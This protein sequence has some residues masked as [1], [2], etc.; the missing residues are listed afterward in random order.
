MD[1]FDGRVAVVTGGGSGIGFEMARAFAAR[2]AK[3]VLAD[4]SKRRLD[5]ARAK[6]EAEGA[7]V[8][9]ERTDVA[10]RGAVEGLADRC[11]SHYGAVHLL[12]NN[13]G[14]AVMGPLL[15]AT[16]KD[17]QRGFGINFW[18]VVHGCEAFV[19]RMLEQGVGAHVVNTAS[20]AGLSGMRGLGVYCASKFAVVGY[21]ESL[22]RELSGSGVG[23]SLLCPMVVATNIGDNSREILREGAPGRTSSQ[24]PP[25]SDVAG[26]VITPDQV[27]A[28]VVRAIEQRRFY[29]LTHEEQRPILERRAALLDE[30]FAPENWN[31]ES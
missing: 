23:V 6:L 21:T 29:V 10:D 4:I 28:R 22:S 18:G 24:P 16:S 17:W 15:E 20:M 30:T 2:G 27:A 8:L 12:C 7:E 11:F 25:R 5:D 14:I 31:T 19:P 3:L 26:S 13:A 1:P 9:A